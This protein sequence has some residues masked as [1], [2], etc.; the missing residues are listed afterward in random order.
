VDD[1]E[2]VM[3]DPFPS[4]APAPKVLTEDEWYD[5]FDDEPKTGELEA[6]QVSDPLEYQRLA[7]KKATASSQRMAKVAAKHT[8]SEPVKMPPS[9]KTD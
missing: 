5:E 4:S 1:L 3:P 7:Q 2:L 6:I 8:P 9:K